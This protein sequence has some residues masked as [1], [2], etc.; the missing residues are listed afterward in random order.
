MAKLRVHNYG[1]SLDGYAAG[2]NQSLE[3]P[4]GEGGEAL[5]EWVFETA[6]GR[7]M[8]GGEGR[9]GSEG[10]ENDI[11][12]RGFENVG[13]WIL[14][15]NMFTASRGDWPDDGWQGW[16]GDEPP[17]HCDTYILTHYKRDPIEMKGGTTFFFV[18]DGIESALEQAFASAKGQDVRVGGGASTVQQYLNAGLIDEMHITVAPVMLGA[19]E[20]LFENVGALEGYDLEYTPFEKAA[21]YRF[22]RST[23]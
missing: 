11:F 22:V 1:C 16:W 5:H 19:G 15:R 18:T 6:A 9:G 14:G 20:R 17:Y 10:A 3:T 21:H 8:F 7:A 23:R 2:P 12:K 13:S 4:L